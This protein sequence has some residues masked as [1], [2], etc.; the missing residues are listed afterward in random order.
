V[1]AA[2][3]FPLMMLIAAPFSPAIEATWSD[4]RALAPIVAEYLFVVAT[5]LV[6]AWC[7]HA[8]WKSRQQLFK[9]RR[10]SSGRY[11]LHSCIGEGGMSY[12]W[13]AWDEQLLR[14][15]ALKILRVGDEVDDYDIARFEREALAASRLQSPHTVR[16]FDFGASDDGIWFIAMEYLAGAD[17]QRVL[18]RGGPM[19]A[20][21][22]VRLGVQICDAIAEE[23]LRVLDFGVSRVLDSTRD[24]LRTDT[25]QFVGTVAYSAPECLLGAPAD[26]ASDIYSIG[27]TL[28]EMLTGENLF[29]GRSGLQLA[30]AHVTTEPEA[31]SV[32]R[33][34]DVPPEL[35]AIVLRCLRK[36][37]EER[38]TSV[39]ELAAALQAASVAITHRAAS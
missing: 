29:K 33:G 11:R 21:R 9:A 28:Y 23:H 5:A 27:A 34:A 26:T 38:F 18:Q 1:P 12:V 22:V 13:L 4:V 8:M 35:D 17:L 3:A 30:A 20:A 24:T 39:T 16:V 14:D 19:S 7:A 37:A 15:V 6:G 36:N 2:L 10:L 32:V 25:G 31:P